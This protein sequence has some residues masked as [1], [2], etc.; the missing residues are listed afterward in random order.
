M[1]CV[2]ELRW[3]FDRSTHLPIHLRRLRRFTAEMFKAGPIETRVRIE[4]ERECQFRQITGAM[5]EYAPRYL[6]TRPCYVFSGRSSHIA[7]RTNF[8]CESVM[9]AMGPN[10]A[11]FDYFSYGQGR[12]KE[13]F[14]NI[15]E[16]E[17]D[18][19]LFRLRSIRF[20]KILVGIFYDVIFKY[21][22]VKFARIRGG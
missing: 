20:K 7:V 10:V 9:E 18:I 22:I 17:Q 3:R 11:F 15:P 2:P 16:R 12:R 1:G 14:M 8:I 21:L 5:L 4:S 13:V 19:G 6:N